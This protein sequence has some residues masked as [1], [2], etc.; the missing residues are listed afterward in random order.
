MNSQGKDLGMGRAISRRD[1]VNGV[2]IATGAGA[3]V[4]AATPS[5]LA[6]G[7]DIA[8]DMMT[9]ANYPPLRT[10]FRGNHPGSNDAAH[11]ERDGKP[12]PEPEDTRETYDLV[13]V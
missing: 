6:Q 9:A 8:G 11:A 7:G 1:F 10:G 13:V 3:A 2:A 5:T 12:L 4:M